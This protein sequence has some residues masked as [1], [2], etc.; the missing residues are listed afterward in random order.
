M[1]QTVVETAIV[2]VV[3]KVVFDR[4]GQSVTEDGQA[5]IVA[6]R[7]LKTVEVVNPSSSDFVA[8]SPPEMEADVV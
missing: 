8:A 6:V 3:T 5:V 2:S 1:G 7:V 4:A